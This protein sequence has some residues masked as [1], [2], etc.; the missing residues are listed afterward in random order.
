[1]RQ[2]LLT[3]T[4]TVIVTSISASDVSAQQRQ[5][6]PVTLTYQPNTIVRTERPIE[7]PRTGPASP[8]T[9]TFPP[10]QAGT[11][12]SSNEVTK[13]SMANRAGAGRDQITS[14]SRDESHS[15]RL[16]NQQ[17]QNPSGGFQ[18]TH[19]GM[20]NPHYQSPNLYL[21]HEFNNWNN[22]RTPLSPTLDP[23]ESVMRTQPVDFGGYYS[24]NTYLGSMYND[25]SNFSPGTVFPNE[26]GG[27]SF[28][29]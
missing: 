13:D 20:S 28:L 7:D 10:K 15:P 3:M 6:P 17:L 24:P 23:F 19:Y 11:A 4:V 14:P 5:L 26:M 9:L 1:M 16:T 12:G 22:L 21:G 8:V 2:F 29:P 25:W 18:L 27:W